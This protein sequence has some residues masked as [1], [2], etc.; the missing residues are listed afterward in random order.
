MHAV[1][2]SDR[3][4]LARAAAGLIA[5]RAADGPMTLGL[6]GGSTPTDTYRALEE[7]SIEWDR[8][9]LWLSDERWVPHDH[10][11]S[12]GRVA[13]EHLP[14][15]ASSR[16]VRPRYSPYVTPTD[17]AV[18]YDAELRY[19]HGDRP[20]DIVLLGMGTDG[21]TA[22]LFSHTEA[23]DA[24]AHRWFVENHVP[25]LDAWRLT[26]TPSLLQRAETV[27]VLVTGSDK[28][29]VLAEVLEGPAGRY[30]IQLLREA[31]GDVTVLCDADAASSLSR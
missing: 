13:L 8:V 31:Q 6:A 14:V 7:V 12:N 10:P 15:D 3:A 26:V 21:H 28:A 18:H 23:L 19:L 25:D 17:S 24:D 30:P 1:V 2:H 27:L 29:T 4:A 22:S 16:L 20:P 5:A 9:S 11:D